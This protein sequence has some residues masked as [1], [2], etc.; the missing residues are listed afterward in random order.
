MS[1]MEVYAYNPRA[2]EAETDRSLTRAGQPALLK[3]Q[4][5]DQ[6]TT[7]EVAF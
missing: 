1:G 7:L 3:W 6:C 5:P 2:G 4:I